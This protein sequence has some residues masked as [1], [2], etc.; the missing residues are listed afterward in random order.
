MS[1]IIPQQSSTTVRVLFSPNT[2]GDFTGEVEFSISSPMNPFNTVPLS[3]TGSEATLLVVPNDLDFG[4]IGVNCSARARTINIFNTGASASEITNIAFSAPANPAY[5]LTNLP[6]LPYN[7]SPG[8]S[9]AFDIGFH[10]DAIASYAGAVEITANFGGQP[11]VY[12][13]TMVGAGAVDAAQTDDFEQLGKPKVDMLWIIDNS[14]SMFEEQTALASN[15]AAFI[16]FAQAQQIDYQIAVTTTDV[17]VGFGGAQ[18][19]FVPTDGSRPRI[20]T[21]NTLPSPEAVFTQNANVGTVGSAFEQGLEAAYLALSAPL[22]NTDNAGFL[23]QD[24][25]LS[26]IFVSDEPDSSPE[27]VD[28]YVNFFLSIKGF[29]NTNLFSASSIVGDTPSG[30]NG[31]GGVAYDGIRYIETAARTGG[32]FQSICT[33]DWSRALEELSTTAFGFKSRFFLSNQPV[34]PTL[35]VYVDSLMLP[36]QGV[37]GTVNWTYDFATNS[38]NFSP[39]ATPEPGAEIRVEYTVECL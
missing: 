7:L 33:S 16:E 9:T 10:A 2:V 29:R 31:P 13:V 15:F 17:D 28:F 11:V 38:I 35:V 14:G 24:A 3:G 1:L 4:I 19:R 27:T 34:I 32:I 12:L 22:I 6:D 5:Q 21:P 30:C 39:F 18:G 26:L 36:A 23:R 25:V 37:G 20:V 8:G